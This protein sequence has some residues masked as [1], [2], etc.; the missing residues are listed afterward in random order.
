LAKLRLR[1]AHRQTGS[2]SVES[3]GN[4]GGAYIVGIAHNSE[5]FKFFKKFGKQNST[6]INAEYMLEDGTYL[7]KGMRKGYTLH[8]P[9][10][11]FYNGQSHERKKA[12]YDA[13]A[14]H[15]K[16]EGVSC[17]VRDYLT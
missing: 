8:F 1:R 6:G 4:C 5:I 3:E 14:K 17:S 15:L 9:T 11:K 2:A 13:A 10:M 7:K 12:F 16:S